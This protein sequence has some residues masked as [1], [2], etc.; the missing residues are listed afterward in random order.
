MVPAEAGE[1]KV[2]S[3]NSGSGHEVSVSAGK[4]VSGHAEVCGCGYDYAGPMSE[5]HCAKNN[6]IH[7]SY[8]QNTTVIVYCQTTN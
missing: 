3:V 4:R 7:H 6:H 5:Q 8:R 1:S 2:L